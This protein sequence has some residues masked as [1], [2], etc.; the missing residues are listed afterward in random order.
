[1][2]GIAREIEDLESVVWDGMH[3]LE[4]LYMCGVVES[5]QKLGIGENQIYL[6]D[7]RKLS[8]HGLQP[9]I[10]GLSYRSCEM[11]APEE[12]MYA[13]SR[14][15]GV[16][17]NG[18]WYNVTAYW[19]G[20]MGLNPRFLQYPGDMM[21]KLYGYLRGELKIPRSKR[22]IMLHSRIC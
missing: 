5:L 2:S 15:D 3:R 19:M 13:R 20:E 18:R 17:F 9:D 11:D 10:Y 12:D 1:M 14:F 22:V 21:K 8:V 7:G 16:A 6:L 4:L